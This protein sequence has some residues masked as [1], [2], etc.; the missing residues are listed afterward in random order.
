MLGQGD[1]D[2]GFHLVVGHVLMREDAAL[3]H[4]D[5]EDGLVSSLAVTV[6]VRITSKTPS[7]CRCPWVCE[8][9]F[10]I[11]RPA[12]EVDLRRVPALRR[13]IPTEFSTLNTGR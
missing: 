12:L 1:G 8:L 2:Q 7:R 3:A 4:L 10:D 9:D 5:Q 11:G 13:E 6:T